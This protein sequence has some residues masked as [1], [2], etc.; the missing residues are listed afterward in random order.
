MAKKP[1]LGALM[2]FF[3]L[4]GA[5]LAQANRFGIGLCLFEPSGLAAKFWLSRQT[6]FDAAIG[7]SAEKNHYLHIHADFVFYNL[8]LAGDSNLDLVFYLGAGGKIIFRDYDNAW[9]RF[10]VGLDFMLKKA[11]LNFFFEVIPSF[12]FSDLKL[13]GA[14]GFRYLFNP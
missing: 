6:A 1:F 10:P 8:R 13:F 9:F 3:F 14:V 5:A 11:P 4:N 12:N 2:A 7:W